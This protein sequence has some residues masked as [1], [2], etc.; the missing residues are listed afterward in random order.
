MTYYTRDPKPD[1]VRRIAA[2]LRRDDILE[3]QYSDPR[4]IL[5][6][7][8][9]IDYSDLCGEVGVIARQDD[10]SPHIIWGV[11]PQFGGVPLCWM[12]GTNEA[13]RNGLTMLVLFSEFQRGV[14]D[15]WGHTRCYTHVTNGVH[16]KWL[17]WFGFKHMWTGP[18][19]P[20]GEQFHM[21]ERGAP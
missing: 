7:Q 14:L 21:Y 4:G 6:L 15:R 9:S 13:E 8:P 3:W 19:G 12:L 11:L 1:D 17:K 16:H 5:M 18:W 2:D 10:D 20:Y